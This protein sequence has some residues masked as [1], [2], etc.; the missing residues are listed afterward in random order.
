[1]PTAPY[2]IAMVE[3][4]HRVL[5]ECFLLDGEAQHTWERRVKDTGIMLNWAYNEPL[6]APV[7]PPARQVECEQGMAKD[8]QA[9][10][11][12]MEQQNGRGTKGTRQ[13]QRKLKVNE[14]RLS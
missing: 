7:I 12:T 8:E 1:M 3:M 9:K 2:L 14:G 10:A 5:W 13:R 11:G 6:E 4:S